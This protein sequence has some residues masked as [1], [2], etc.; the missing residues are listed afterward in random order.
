[1]ALV[2][3]ALISGPSLH[4]RDNDSK[5]GMRCS[6]LTHFG[7]V[8]SEQQHTLASGKISSRGENGHPFRVF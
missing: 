2:G 6:I 7:N 1:M 8:L 5:A 4:E 3:Q